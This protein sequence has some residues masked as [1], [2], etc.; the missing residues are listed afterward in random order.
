[1]LQ[2]RFDGILAAC[3]PGFD[4]IL[5]SRSSRTPLFVTN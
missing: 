1:V 2:F 3:L 4:G 5:P